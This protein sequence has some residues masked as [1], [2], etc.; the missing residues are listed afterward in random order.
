MDS[1]RRAVDFRLRFRDAAKDAQGVFLDEVREVARLQQGADFDVGTPV[2]IGVVVVVLGVVVVVVLRVVVVI[3]SVG[4]SLPGVSVLMLKLM[5][6]LVLMCVSVNLTML[7]GVFVLIVGMNTARVDAELHSLNVLA[8]FALEVHVEVSDVQLGE[9][10]LEGRGLHS[11]VA[12][13]ADGHVAADAGE[14][15]EKENSHRRIRLPRA[16]PP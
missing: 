10:P 3:M 7:V 14:T 9:L 6:M 16:A 11:Q 4:M 13:R 8:L 12:E 1:T 15:I 5:F 2:G